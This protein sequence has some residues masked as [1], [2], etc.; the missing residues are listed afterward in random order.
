MQLNKI[1]NRVL[2]LLLL[3]NALPLCSSVAY[4]SA[5]CTSSQATGK[6]DC[7]IQ[8]DFKGT[9]VE[10][11]CDVD[12]NS[13]GSSPIISLPTISIQQLLK[14]GSE[15]GSKLFPIKLRNC[16]A[17]KTINLHFISLSS[18]SGVDSVTGNLTNNAGQGMSNN[19]Q[20]RLRTDN[21]TQLIIDDDNSYQEYQIP[22]SGGDVS[23]NFIVS[24]YAKNTNAVTPGLVSAS[25]IVDLI[26]K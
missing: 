20:L 9:F 15:A 17:G 18:S 19:I 23:H 16:P 2:L 25:V 4:A 7:A 22:S 24:Y 10:D 8:L 5:S 14:A 12:I 1:T 26:Y 11:T 21:L 6:T 3:A 13:S